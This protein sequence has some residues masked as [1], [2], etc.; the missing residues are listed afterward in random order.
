MPLSLIERIRTF[1]LQC[2]ALV[3]WEDFLLDILK[4]LRT[5]PAH[6]PAST[7]TN[8]YTI[9]FY[10]RRRDCSKDAPRCRLRAAAKDRSSSRPAAALSRL[11]SAQTPAVVVHDGLLV[12]VDH[13]AAPNTKSSPSMVLMNPAADEPLLELV[14]RSLSGELHASRSAPAPPTWP[15]QSNLRAVVSLFRGRFRAPRAT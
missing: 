1:Y 7:Q 5:R 4:R 10:H 12:R 6:G 2:V 9:F 8:K 15:W 13:L 11:G 3:F 14:E